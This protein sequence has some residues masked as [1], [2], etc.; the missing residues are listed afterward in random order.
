V[1]GEDVETEAGLEEE[2]AAAGRGGGEDEGH[3]D[4]VVV[5]ASSF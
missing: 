4:W 5:L 2:V 1:G 3:W